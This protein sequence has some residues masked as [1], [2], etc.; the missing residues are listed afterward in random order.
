MRGCCAETNVLLDF[1]Q[2]VVKGSIVLIGCPMD[3]VSIIDLE[4]VPA[5]ICG[6][7]VTPEK[8]SYTEGGTFGVADTL[9]HWETGILD[10]TFILDT[11]DVFEGEGPRRL[12]HDRYFVGL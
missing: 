3:T 12:K 6:F 10:I 9:Y 2:P 5:G 11:E 4:V 7:K 1:R 8:E